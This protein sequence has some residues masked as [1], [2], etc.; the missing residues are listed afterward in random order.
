M[1][2]AF[3]R[4]LQRDLGPGQYQAPRPDLVGAA[5][6]ADAPADDAE[7]NDHEDQ[8]LLEVHAPQSPDS[9]TGFG[10]SEAAEQRRRPEQRSWS[11]G[12]A[13]GD[14]APK[15]E[16]AQ[17]AAKPRSVDHREFWDASAF[18]HCRPLQCRSIWEIPTSRIP[19]PIPEAELE[20]NIT[21][22]PIV[23]DKTLRLPV[24]ATTSGGLDFQPPAAGN[25]VKRT[26][27]FRRRHLVVFGICLSLAT[28]A[29]AAIVSF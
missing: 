2:S 1:V 8:E 5:E 20:P 13:C 3:K 22:L 14:D 6:E 9:R 21:R 11:S 12:S 23:A 25:L 15:A 10:T 16:K 27:A 26:F 29:G 24:I 7:A 4:K 18:K 17:K 19:E 28:V